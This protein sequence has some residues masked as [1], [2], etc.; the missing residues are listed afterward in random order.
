MRVLYISS[1][2]NAPDGSSVHGRAFVRNVKKLGFQIE[3]YP[4]IRDIDYLQDSQTRDS[5]SILHK[6]RRLKPGPAIKSRIRRLGRLAGDTVDIVD[7]L[8]ETMRY[9]LGA[10][11]VIKR[12]DPD[13]LVFRTTLFNFAPQLIKKVYAIPCVAE[14][15]SIK[16]L[17]ISV[18]SNAGMLARFTRSSEQ[19]AI[20]RSDRVFVVSE[21]IKKFVDQF[22]PPHHCKVV[23]NGVETDEFDPACFD[24]SAIKQSLG[25]K[26][27]VVLGYVGSYKTWHGLDISLDLIKLLTLDQGKYALLLIGNGETYSRIKSRIQAE[28]L[29]DCVKQ[30]DYVPHTD[31]P[32]YTAAFDYAVMTYPDFE[33][34][35]FSPL[36]M[37]E[38]MSMGTPIVS[39]ETGQIASII[40][41]QETGILV[42]PPTPEQFYQAIV[43]L[44]ETQEQYRNISQNSRSEAVTHHSW[45]KNAEQVLGICAE[46][47]GHQS[48]QVS[49]ENSNV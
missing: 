41:D 33:G 35:Y 43:K 17:E 15:N 31:V 13:V 3:T 36:K 42:H 47:T 26:G 24:K 5:N 39:T 30:I 45:L 18:A 9:F 37:Y 48:V 22:Y 49:A 20:T 2:I 11:T 12:F 27:K 8:L 21:A 40:R 7:G 19:F 4:Q 44:E 38:Y 1:R 46:L 16:Y 10:R 32:K 34:F 14:V 25:L 29:G 6:I 23:P 28:G